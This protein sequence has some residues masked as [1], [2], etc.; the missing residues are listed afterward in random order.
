M[1]TK[2]TEPLKILLLEEAE[3]NAISLARLLEHS[4]L[5]EQ[6]VR[7]EGLEAALEIAGKLAID[8]CLLD[9]SAAGTDRLN[10]LDAIV[11]LSKQI[12][13]I[14]LTESVG[15]ADLQKILEAGAEDY[16]QRDQL[17]PDILEWTI[18][19]TLEK[20]S[21]RR[22]TEG[23]KATFNR[24]KELLRR[25]FDI[26]SDAILI[27]S[28]AYEIKFFNPAAANLLD[29]SEDQLIGEIFPFEISP[30]KST[31]LE[32]PDANGKTRLVELASDEIFWDGQKSQFI[33]LRDITDL[34]NAKL[35]VEHE[36]ALF[37][38]ALDA[39]D[40]AVIATD[41]EG[42]IE[43]INREACRLTGFEKEAALGRRLGQI[44][45]LKNSETNEYLEA[46]C[47]ELL[48]R[49]FI[50]RANQDG[51]LLDSSG[52]ETPQLVN[53]DMRCVFDEEGTIHRCVTILRDLRTQKELER[54]LDES[55][56]LNTLSLTA[57]G[58]AHDFNNILTSILGNISIA[59][60]RMDE[61]DANSQQLLAAE[62]AALQAKSLTQQL[63]TFAKGGLPSREATTIGELVEESAQ[64]IMRGSN[65][66]CEIHR[67]P[68][69]WPVDVDRGQIA[70]V[71]NNLLINAD[72][73]MPDG[74]RIDLTLE[75]TELRRAHSAGLPPGE[76]VKIEVADNGTGIPAEK[77]DRIFDPYFTTKEGGSGLGLASSY[78]IIKRHAG[79]I[80]VE[81][82]PGE[83]SRFSVYLP[84]SLKQPPGEMP[85]GDLPPEKKEPDE[86]ASAS[87]RSRRIL[88]MDDME[89]MMLVAG[90]ILKMLGYE[91]EC[92]SDGKA[93]IE[94]YKKA[95]EAGN[96]FDAVVFDLTVPGGMGGEEASSLLAQYDPD[97]RAIA[98]SGYTTS[99]IMADY[100]DSAFKAVV[101]KPYRINEMKE[102]LERVLN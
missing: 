18:R 102:A 38:V 88:I 15:E 91:V 46:D 40:A 99:N 93:A 65:V 47:R 53:A 9:L 84:R 51:L 33:L 59:R 49:Q 12:P 23:S 96:P 79:K 22:R 6:L 44:L 92:T 83:G 61:S 90:E 97:L 89:D 32:I 30:G 39:L 75:N 63:L 1:P 80:T 87:G 34:K 11:P 69:L 25:I 14:V 8:L 74:G 27:L 50:D 85:D 54:E 71:V 70:Q 100:R 52:K 68:E 82:E 48:D 78:S 16:I 64:F 95:K 17:T 94:A 45:R 81:S 24:D 66:K 2:R 31:E 41:Q 67:S 19:H 101:P 86:D 10:R 58:I 55:E 5:N 37:S 35:A 42:R 56:S 7:S 28:D 76:Y 29:A 3:E 57:G 60:M 36:K 77:L 98:S 13:V 4:S 26:N 72:Q 73:A 20:A 62:K 43:R 21:M